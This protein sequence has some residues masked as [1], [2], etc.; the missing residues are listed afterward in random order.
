MKIF[1]FYLD[2][3]DQFFRNTEY[4][5]LVR[6]IETNTLHYKSIIESAIQSS[7]PEPSLVSADRFEEDVYDVLL[8]HRAERD[9]V[10]KSKQN[11]DPLA[12]AAA[13][14]GIDGQN[15]NGGDDDDEIDEGEKEDNPAYL[16]EFS[17]RLY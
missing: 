12:A 9:A 14:A 17:R 15:A 10:N 11:T 7:L 13:A 16:E 1:K 4:R 6:K 2:D 3:L 5:S 8:K